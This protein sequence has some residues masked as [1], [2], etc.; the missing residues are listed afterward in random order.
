M[1]PNLR[2]ITLSHPVIGTNNIA[3]IFGIIAAHEERH[4]GQMRRV[5]ENPRFPQ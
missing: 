4:H 3:Q 2:K 1:P 5:M